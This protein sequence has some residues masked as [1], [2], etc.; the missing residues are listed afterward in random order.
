MEQWRRLP[1]GPPVALRDAKLAPRNVHVAKRR[2]H[3]GMLVALNSDEPDTFLSH[4]LKMT[5]LLQTH[6]MRPLLVFDGDVLPIQAPNNRQR[7]EERVRCR[8]R[9][10]QRS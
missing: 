9:A 8:N 6:G 10:E 7:Q 3:K 2:R 1:A 5:A 4:P